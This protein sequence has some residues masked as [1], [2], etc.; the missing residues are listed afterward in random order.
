VLQ[1][2]LGERMRLKEL[3]SERVAAANDRAI[4]AVAQIVQLCEEIPD[5]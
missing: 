1:H 2:L 3:G 5:V 4:L